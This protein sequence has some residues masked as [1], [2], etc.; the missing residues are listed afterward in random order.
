M[1]FFAVLSTVLVV[2]YFFGTTLQKTEEIEQLERAGI[3]ASNLVYV[4]SNAHIITDFH[5]IEDKKDKDIGTTKRGNGPA[6]RDKYGRR[7][8]RAVEDPR[9]RKNQRHLW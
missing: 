7:G 5:R 6:Y 4:S 2:A 8:V 3:P 1:R 9:K